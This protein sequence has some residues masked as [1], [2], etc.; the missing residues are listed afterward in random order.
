MDPH[1]FVQKVRRTMAFI[2]NWV[3]QPHY[4]PEIYVQ[5]NPGE[6]RWLHPH[7]L[8]GRN[9]GRLI[10]TGYTGPQYFQPAVPAYY[11]DGFVIPQAPQP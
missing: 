3:L 2:T 10:G 9:T 4:A 6:F 5:A 1:D 8:Y 7:S 11:P